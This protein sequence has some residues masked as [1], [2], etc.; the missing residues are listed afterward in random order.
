MPGESEHREPETPS[1]QGVYGISVAAE[2]SGFGAG[3]LRLYEEY[4]LI[5]PVRTDGGT[6]RYSDYDL[7]RLKRI[8]ELIDAGVNLVGIGRVLDLETR[9]GELEGDNR[10]LEVDNAR[11]RADRNPGTGRN[12]PAGDLPPEVGSTRAGRRR[13]PASRD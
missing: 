10:R 8:A 2:L 3:A 9:T 1:M 5:T 7:V 11:L 6:R 4:G 12:D 13:R